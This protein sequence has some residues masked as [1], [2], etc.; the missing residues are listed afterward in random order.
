MISPRLPLS[1][2]RRKGDLR[3]VCCIEFVRVWGP[4][5]NPWFCCLSFNDSFS[6]SPPPPRL[7]SCRPV[8]DILIPSF[9]ANPHDRRDTAG[10]VEARARVWRRR[11]WSQRGKLC[12]PTGGVPCLLPVEESHTPS[13]PHHHE[14]VVSLALV[15]DS[16]LSSRLGSLG[17]SRMLTET[18]IFSFTPYSDA[19]TRGGRRLRSRRGAEV[20][21]LCRY[22]PVYLT[23]TVSDSACLLPA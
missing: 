19:T 22:G 17:E 14:R 12:R 6:A 15:A 11:K 9:C 1:R 2:R 13:S 23:C 10:N 18:S 8:A 4:F 7:W 16:V 20:R 3:C 5:I 21:V